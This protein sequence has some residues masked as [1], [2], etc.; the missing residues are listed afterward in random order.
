[1]SRAEVCKP[2][3]GEKNFF[4][5]LYSSARLKVVSNFHASEYNSVTKYTIV[6]LHHL[7]ITKND[8]QYAI[9]KNTALSCSFF[10]YTLI[11]RSK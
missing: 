10:Y 5:R 6:A 9:I 4:R 3:K 8:V 7:N 1:M 11:I 2:K